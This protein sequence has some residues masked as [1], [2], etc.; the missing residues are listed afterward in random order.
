MPQTND[1]GKTQQSPPQPLLAQALASV[2]NAIFITN[3][4]GQIIWVNDAFSQLSGYSSE[5]AIGR[6]PAILQS[7]R[8]RHAFYAQLWQTIL[9]GHVWQGEIIDQ[10][11]D[12][13]LYTVD[14]VI[15]PLFDAQGTITHFI[16]I[17]HDI[18]QLKQESERDHHLA[19]HDILTDLPNRALF[20]GVQQKA[21]SHAKR[22]QHM[23]ATLFLDL[24]GFKPVNDTLG[25]H[26]GDQL[27]TAVAD[28]LRASVRQTDTV[29]RFGGDEFAVL[30]TDLL[31]TEVASTLARKMLDAIA[32]PF[33]LRGQK[34]NVSA[35]IGIAIYPSDGE[36]PETLL[37]NADKAMYQAK[38]HGGNN[39]QI[40]NPAPPQIH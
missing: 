39:Y 1:S 8:H 37:I 2:A 7:G 17:Q 12:G 34:I 24:D 18:T 20:L 23:L 27:L 22:T 26:T 33:V 4:V 25:H 11:K 32:R 6:P 10:R 14:E 36:D 29:A 30:I 21:I 31:D 35:S 13:S 5:D 19:Y 3:E 28:R 40:Y 38:C 15:T 16:A 9:A